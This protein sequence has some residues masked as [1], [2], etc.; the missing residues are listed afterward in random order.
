MTTITDIARKLSISVATVSRALNNKDG[1]SAKLR[2]KIYETA[3]DMGYYPNLK[4]RAMVRGMTETIGVIIPRSAEF[5]FSN[6]FYPSILSAIASHL[7]IKNY[8]MLLHFESKESYASL[9]HKRLVDGNII[10]SNKIDDNKIIELA[11]KNIPTVLIPGFTKDEKD[12]IKKN[13]PSVTSENIESLYNATN[14]LIKLGHKKIAFIIGTYNSKYSLERLEG[15]IKAHK[16]NNIP[17]K[18]EYICES[19]FSKSDGFNLME[20]LLMTVDRPTSIIGIN[21]AVTVGALQSIYRNQLRIP[22][23]ISVISIGGTDYVKDFWPAL[24]TIENPIKQI[25]DK[26]SEMIL[27]IINNVKIRKRNLTIAAQLI[28]RESTAKPDMKA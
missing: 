14:Y 6:P 8:N 7:E 13:I 26:A 10:L 24:T 5:T 22:E 4:A 12:P 27:K 28:I 19:D 18:E 16:K 15:Y 23:D 1:V 25:G 21:D 9:Y 20:K 17:I 11:E 2:E 3:D